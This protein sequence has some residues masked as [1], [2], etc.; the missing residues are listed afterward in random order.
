MTPVEKAVKVLRQGGVVAYPTETVYGLGANIFDLK[1]VKKIFKLKGRDFKKPMTVAVADWQTLKDLVFLTSSQEKLL[2]KILPG[3]YTILLPKK[4]KVS[5]IITSGHD[6]VGIR[7]PANRLPQELIKKA[8]FPLT[9]TSANLSGQAE[10]KRWQDLGLKPDYLIKGRCYYGQAST[11]IDLT[12]KAIIRQGAG[13]VSK[14][15]FNCLK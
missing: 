14:T 1:A 10:A 3:P 8:G 11:V 13:Q 2:K 5:K 12:Q 7:W 6:L 15:F 9:A 4:K